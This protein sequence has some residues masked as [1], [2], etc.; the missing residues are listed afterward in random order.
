MSRLKENNI[1]YFISLV[2]D[3]TWSVSVREDVSHGL[4]EE[5]DG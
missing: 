4:Q 2:I 5:T 3:A 1:K